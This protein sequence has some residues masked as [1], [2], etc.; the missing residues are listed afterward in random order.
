MLLTMEQSKYLE[1]DG[2]AFRFTGQNIANKRE[3]QDLKDFD[4]SCVDIYGK[5]MI[6]NYTELE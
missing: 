3:K 2:D 1:S 4:E 5:H 6:T